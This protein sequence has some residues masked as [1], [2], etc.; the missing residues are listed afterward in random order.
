MLMSLVVKTCQLL[1]NIHAG[2]SSNNTMCMT[3]NSILLRQH[4]ALVLVS[5]AFAYS[6]MSTFKSDV[7]NSISMDLCEKDLRGRNSQFCCTKSCA[8]S[9]YALHLALLIFLVQFPSCRV[10][11][12]HAKPPGS[13]LGNFSSVISICFSAHKGLC[14]DDLTV[15]TMP[16]TP[17]LRGGRHVTT[18]CI[19]CR[20]AKAKVCQFA[21]C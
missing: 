9:S 11:G 19:R 5:Y 1:D 6:Q 8:R 3:F 14:L 7:S 15:I 17:S 18:A 2:I 21:V 20:D 12:A 4:F 10:L 16:S 13:S